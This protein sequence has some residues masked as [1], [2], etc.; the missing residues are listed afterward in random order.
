MNRIILFSFI[1]LL[2][3]SKLYANSFWNTIV[4]NNNSS[5][6]CYAISDLQRYISEVNGI[7][8]NLKYTELWKLSTTECIMI[9]LDDDNEIIQKLDIDKSSINEQGYIIYPTEI[10][11]NK[12]LVITAKTDIGLFNGIYGLLR[13]AGFGFYLGSESIPNSIPEIMPNNPII[14]SPALKTRG[15]LPWYNFLNSPTNWNPIDYRSFVDL[16]VRSGAN[17]IGFHTYDHEPFGAYEDDGKMVLGKRLQNTSESVWGT[18]PMQTR[19]FPYRLSNI[20]SNEYFGA[21]SSLNIRDNDIAI[22]EEQRILSDAFRYAKQRGLKT[23]IGIEYSGNPFD[24]NTQNAFTIRFQNLIKTYPDCDYI[25]IWQPEAVGAS[26]YKIVKNEESIESDLMYPFDNINK[27]NCLRRDLFK[28]IVD[29]KEAYNHLIRLDNLGKTNRANEAVRMEQFTMLAYNQL[30]KFDNPPKLIISGWGGD[31]RL[32]SAEYYEGL[33]KIL[34]KDIIFSSLDNIIP[35]PYVDKIYSE[36]PKT[37]ERWPIPWIEYDGDQWQPQPYVYVYEQMMKNILDSG[38]QGVLGIHWRTKDLDENYSYMIE[39]S[40]NPNLSADDFFEQYSASRYGK[41]IADEMA[42]IHKELDKLGY[43]WVGGFGQM[44]CGIFTWHHG[45]KEKID[46]LKELKIKS[47]NLLNQSQSDTSQLEWLINVMDWVIKYYQIEKVGHEVNSIID[48]FAISDEATVKQSAKTALDLMN[49]VD[50]ADLLHTFTT[51]INSRGEYGVLATVIT[52]AWV[53]WNKDKAKLAEILGIDNKEEDNQWKPE[54][55]IILP[56]FYGSIEENNDFRIECISLGGEDIYLS[57]RNSTSKFWKTVKMNTAQ[58]WVKEYKIPAKDVISP[59]LQINFSYSNTSDSSESVKKA[60]TVM[61][62]QKPSKIRQ[63]KKIATGKK[64]TGVKIETDNT[65][66]VILTW[67][68][69]DNADWYVI[70]RDE[71]KIAQT[72]VCIYPDS[73]LHIKS[74]YK[75]EAI[76]NNKIIAESDV[77]TYS[78]PDINIKDDIDLY[79]KAGTKK[80]ILNWLS[81]KTLHTSYY[82]I[83]KQN[84][85]SDQKIEKTIQK[86]TYNGFE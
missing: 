43:R 32:L 83:F 18:T 20:F 9:G 74:N 49:S 48:Q 56:S 17:F 31:K 33:D 2:C 65:A 57:Y 62:T 45:S 21:E 69:V 64:I 23:C 80:V 7:T 68:M 5:S 85:D 54:R 61:P 12:V 51:R 10:N 14:K 1:I 38:S 11:G 72:A 37:R 8:P 70:K 39:K 4:T 42:V 41:D 6:V 73:P 44:E 53:K 34:P 26:G 13:W 29:L 55:K 77:I 24:K 71:K 30:Q 35:L 16:L 76:S 58:G 78:I 36:L 28:R 75:I 59:I 50:F 19:D 79:I 63:M 60:I 22:K 67:D 66:P 82:K 81:P 25:W 3:F 40:W 15:V 84:V 27:Y 86:P 46:L 52:K 47:E